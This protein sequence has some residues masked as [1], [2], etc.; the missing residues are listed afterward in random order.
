MAFRDFGWVALRTTA[1]D[2]LGLV[3]YSLAVALMETVLVFAVLLLL[4]LLIP[5]SWPAGKRATLLGTLFLLLASWAI[6]SKLFGLY[7]SPI[8]EGVLQALRLGGHPLRMAWGVV[9]PLVAASIAL[10]VIMFVRSRRFQESLPGVFD[11]LVVLSSF[12]IFLDFLG[13]LIIL[14]RNFHAGRGT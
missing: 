10:P 3:A 5:W 11:R 9:F 1:W 4:G 13:L 7:G 8:P 14:V 2:A 6:F 12:Y